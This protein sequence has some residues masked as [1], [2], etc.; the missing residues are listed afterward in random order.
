MIGLNS[1]K[2]LIRYPWTKVITEVKA[3]LIRRKVPAKR[4]IRRSIPFPRRM[5]RPSLTWKIISR[6]VLKELNTHVEAQ[7]SPPMP[8][9]P[10]ILRSRT[11]LRM[12]FMILVSG[13]GKAFSK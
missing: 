1:K 10:T 3:I 12:L 8:N 9:T 6:A 11:I 2:G 5:P 7:I 13:K 4:I